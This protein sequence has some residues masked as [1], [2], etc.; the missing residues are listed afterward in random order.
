MFCYTS[1]D[2]FRYTEKSYISKKEYFIGFIGDLVPGKSI[3]S[4]QVEGKLI[5]C[6]LYVLLGLSLM[7]M[8]FNLMQE[9]VRAKFRRLGN[10]LGIIDDP[11]YW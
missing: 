2:R 9:E 6:A 7:A 11:N 5:I 3:T 8:C 1:N 4:T 10:K